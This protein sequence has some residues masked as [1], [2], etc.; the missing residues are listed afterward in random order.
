VA[1]RLL[2]GFVVIDDKVH[3]AEWDVQAVS[4]SIAHLT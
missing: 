4:F 1:P 3:L 2:P